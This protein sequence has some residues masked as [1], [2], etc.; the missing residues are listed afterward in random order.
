[1][2][3]PR[4]S[5]SSEAE[6]IPYADAL[7]I[8]ERVGR[9]RVLEAERVPLAAAIGRALAVEV[10]SPEALP[11]ADNSGVDGFALRAAD[12]AGASAAAPV[13]LI[14]AGS[15]AAGDDPALGRSHGALEIMTGAALPPGFDAVIRLEDVTV[16]KDGNGAPVAVTIGRSLGPRQ[17]VRLR[18]EDFR[19]GD[20]VAT[21]G[22]V[23]R[24]GHVMAL[25]ALGVTDVSVRRRPRVAVICTGKELV[26][27]DTAVLPPGAIRDSTSA[28]LA[29]AVP[30]LGAEVIS[31]AW[32]G[33]DRSALRAGVVA[34]G[35]A[36]ADLVLTTGAVSMGKHD[37]VPE[38]LRDLGASVL[39]HKISV[40]PGKPVLLAELPGGLPVVGLP[41]NPI[42]SAVS[43]RFLVAPLLRAMLGRA[44][45]RPLRARLARD[46][47]KPDGLRCFFRA[48]VE[49][50]SGECVVDVLDA[51]GSA[52]LSSLVAANAW[53]VLP[54]AGRVASAG[55][56]VDAVPLTGAEAWP[57][58]PSA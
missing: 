46:T 9:Q 54:E 1:M 31:R 5:R 44:P 4:A 11:G 50:G 48:V 2:G 19:E 13:T 29:A 37:F 51:Q 6:P 12:V 8:A 30:A 53:A 47:R 23:I 28:Y 14:V 35:E 15:H 45:E 38:V 27:P 10:R 57:V 22:E 33:D 36:R 58:S 26:P 3:T 39:F 42:A 56:E 32:T 55:T 25:S 24:P 18:G 49:V 34:A 20:R 17:D 41:G 52:I 7:A 40:R 21:A 43:T 16:R